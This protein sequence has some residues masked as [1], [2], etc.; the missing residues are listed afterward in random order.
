MFIYDAFSLLANT[1]DKH[2]LV[3]LIVESPKISCSLGQPWFNGPLLMKYL[4]MADFNGLSGHIEFDQNTGFR[5]NLTISI[6]DKAD[7]GVDLFGYWRE[8]EKKR[9]IEIIRSYAKEKSQILNKLNRNL[10]VT[11]KLVNNILFHTQKR[12]KI[13]PLQNQLRFLKI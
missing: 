5:K 11:T 2:N 9:P 8:K 6:V 7:V 4:K 12:R 10:K 1:L 13:C 3:D